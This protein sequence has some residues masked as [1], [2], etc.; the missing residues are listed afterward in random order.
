MF[1]KFHI[2]FV[3]YALC[4][5]LSV[6]CSATSLHQT[7]SSYEFPSMAK[8]RREAMAKVKFESSNALIDDDIY[9]INGTFHAPFIDPKRYPICTDTIWVAGTFHFRMM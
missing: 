2:V 7:K 8:R 5:A 6:L 4:C 1:C 3:C 9:S